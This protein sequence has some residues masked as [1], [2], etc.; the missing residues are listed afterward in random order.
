MNEHHFHCETSCTYFHIFVIL[1]FIMS[2][3]HHTIEWKQGNH[4]LAFILY[5]EC[6]DSLVDSLEITRP[7]QSGSRCGSHSASL[8]LSLW[9]VVIQVKCGRL[10]PLKPTDDKFVSKYWNKISTMQDFLLFHSLPKE[11][12]YAFWLLPA[13]W[14]CRKRVCAVAVGWP[15]WHSGEVQM[16]GALSLCFSCTNK[17]PHNTIVSV[18]EAHIDKGG[19]AAVAQRQNSAM[20]TG[21]WI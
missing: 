18:W 16:V 4:N 7:T 3:S 15:L 14:G 21:W 17:C 9:E 12:F 11:F 20:E 6:T 19:N 1:Q 10:T 8:E 2:A 13:F 5:A